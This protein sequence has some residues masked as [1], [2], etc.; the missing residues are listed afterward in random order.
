MPNA[1]AMDATDDFRF[2]ALHL[3]AER[4]GVANRSR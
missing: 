2:A 1:K 3:N 4:T